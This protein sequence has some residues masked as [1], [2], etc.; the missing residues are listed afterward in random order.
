MITEELKV[1]FLLFYGLIVYPFI[2]KLCK[3]Y[4]IGKSRQPIW[5]IRLYGNTH[6]LKYLYK[7]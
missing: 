2:D 4:I 1:Q 7:Q 5:L 3:Q 6:T